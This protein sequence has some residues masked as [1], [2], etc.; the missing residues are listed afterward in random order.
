MRA[1]RTDEGFIFLPSLT[2]PRLVTG[3]TAPSIDEVRE[4]LHSLGT[5]PRVHNNGFIQLD[6]TGQRRLHIWGHLDIPQAKEKAFVHDHIFGFRSWG[7]IGKLKNIIYDLDLNGNKYEIYTPKI[8]RGCDSTLEPTG[9][10]CDVK[11]KHTD[12]IA[13]RG[14]LD[15]LPDSYCIEPYLFHETFVSE[16][17]AT[18]IEKTGSTLA[19]NPNGPRPRVLVPVGS[20]P[21]DQFSRHNTDERLLWRIIEEVLEL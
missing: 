21:D 6:L 1:N 12:V 18:V 4:Y 2:R 17:T 11:V 3:N 16:P 9:V 14:N 7:L 15:G 19:Q 5:K 10:F 20:K 8:T 13:A